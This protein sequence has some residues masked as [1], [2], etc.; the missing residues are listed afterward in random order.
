MTDFIE[1]YLELLIFQYRD[2]PNASAEIQAIINPFNDVFDLYNSFDS[3]FDVDSGIGEQLNILG[4]IL[5]QNRQIEK[6]VPK[7]YF[8][9]VNKNA[10]AKEFGHPFFKKGDDLFA[11]LDLND[12]EYRFFLKLKIAKNN[13]QNNIF[14]VSELVS[15]ALNGFGYIE[16]NQDMTLTFNLHE[17][18]DVEF[19]KLFVILDMLP[20]PMGIRYNNYIL[21]YDDLGNKTTYNL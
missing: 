8:G 5:G 18:F 6:A 15:W 1:A 3:A 17:S 10:N 16:N 2:K 9:F 7:E 11:S 14:N 21:I 4:R 13:M 19:G 20:R 12:S